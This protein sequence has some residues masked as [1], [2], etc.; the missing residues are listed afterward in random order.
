MPSNPYLD[1]YSTPFTAF[2]DMMNYRDYIVVNGV[3]EDVDATIIRRRTKAI[4]LRTVMNGKEIKLRIP[5][6]SSS[7]RLL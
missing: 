6:R 2:P 1:E 4:V 5:L 3:C 7:R